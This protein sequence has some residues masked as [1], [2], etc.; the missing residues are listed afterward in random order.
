M[1]I[2]D[3]LNENDGAIIAIATVFLVVVTLIYVCETRK[4]R[5]TSQ[6]LTR[7]YI[8]GLVVAGNK[9]LRMLPKS[10]SALIP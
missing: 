7:R 9:M 5:K 1:F 10:V 2:I 3:F 4:I 8:A 6:K